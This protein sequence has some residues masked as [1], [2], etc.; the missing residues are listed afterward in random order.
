MSLVRR[1]GGLYPSFMEDF[2]DKNWS[3][4][5]NGFDTGTRVP[6]VNVKE[7]DDS[8]EIQLA[9]PGMEKENFEINVENNI[10]SISAETKSENEEKDENGKY[11]KRE[12]SFN[13]FKRSFSLP[14]SVDDEDIKANYENGILK[15]SIPKKEEARPKPPRQIA[16][17]SN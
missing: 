8:F 14:E 1:T 13:S 9:A 7:A 2:F 12:F 10:L 15:L 5:G 4:Q 3:G 17:G 16:I 11:T 6:A